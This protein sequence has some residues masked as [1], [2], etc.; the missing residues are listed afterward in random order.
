MT[1]AKAAPPAKPPP[2]PPAAPPQPEPGHVEVAAE[3]PAIEHRPFK[4]IYWLGQ[5]FNDGCWRHE[6]R[7][8]KCSSCAANARAYTAIK[9][10]ELA[11]YLASL[12]A[13]R[14][15][16]AFN[17]AMVT[18]TFEEDEKFSDELKVRDWA[19]YAC[20]SIIDDVTDAP[21]GTA[22]AADED[23]EALELQRRGAPEHGRPHR[24]GR[25]R[26]PRRGHARRSRAGAGVPEA[27]W[28]GL[29]VFLCVSH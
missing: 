4:N 21:G 29:S 20:V 22:D 15:N 3:P 11:L 26:L 2:A 27:V 14:P 19:R 13:F 17:G 16:V 28:C 7:C 5:R 6:A 1:N 24:R 8:D 12:R 25:V 18:V 23:E 9:D 10:A